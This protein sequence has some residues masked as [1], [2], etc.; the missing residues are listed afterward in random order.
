ME[1]ELKFSIGTIIHEKNF[2]DI[3]CRKDYKFSIK[4]IVFGLVIAILA[5]AICGF[6]SV[7]IAGL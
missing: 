6:T 1:A 5:G 7:V 4:R 2:R 3:V